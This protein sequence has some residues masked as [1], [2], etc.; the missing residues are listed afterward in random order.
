MC[1]LCCRGYSEGWQG[2]WV[3]GF[4]RGLLFFFLSPLYLFVVVRE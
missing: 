1:Q 2:R 3:A 4:K